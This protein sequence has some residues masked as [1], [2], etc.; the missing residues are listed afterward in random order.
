MM[1]VHYLRQALAFNAEK[2]SGTRDPGHAPFRKNF[3]GSCPE[4]P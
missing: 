1:R 4:C 3:W 2:F